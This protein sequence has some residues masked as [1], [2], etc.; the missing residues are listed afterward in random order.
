[1]YIDIQ[2][3]LFSYFLLCTVRTKTLLNGTIG[4]ILDKL[5]CSS[6]TRLPI[7]LFLECCTNLYT[8]R[9]ICLDMDVWC[10]INIIY[11]TFGRNYK[12]R[13]YKTYTFNLYLYKKYT[14]VYKLNFLNVL[15][16][17]TLHK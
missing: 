17:Y 6:P 14:F 16:E 9:Y 13:I 7:H 3:N 5:K 10:V 12:A 8:Y 1:M 11:N 15:Y 2:L 4:N